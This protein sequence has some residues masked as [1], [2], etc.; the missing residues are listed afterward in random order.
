MWH[1]ASRDAFWVLLLVQSGLMFL[2]NWLVR[3]NWTMDPMQNLWYAFTSQISRVLRV[4]LCVSGC[5]DPTAAGKKKAWSQ[6]EHQSFLWLR[7]ISFKQTDAVY[8]RQKCS[9]HMSLSVALPPAQ[10]KSGVSVEDFC[11]KAVLTVLKRTDQPL[12]III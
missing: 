8:M 12:V 6:S 3:C 5:F 9:C 2:F 4:W 11:F 10:L 7:V 1:D